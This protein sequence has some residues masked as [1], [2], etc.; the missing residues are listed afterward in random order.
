MTSLELDVQAVRGAILGL[1]GDGKNVILLSHSFGGI[2]ASEA[3]KGLGKEAWEKQGHI[4]CV[5]KLIY[6]CAFALPK[7]H[8]VTTVMSPVTRE[9]GN[10]LRTAQGRQ[11]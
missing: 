3:V 5:V 8:F 4:S 7:S 2:T 1:L 10:A 11:A 6:M 9:E